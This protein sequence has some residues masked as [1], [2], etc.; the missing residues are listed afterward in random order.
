MADEQRNRGHSLSSTRYAAR[1]SIRTWPESTPLTNFA[2]LS[3][4]L[5]VG[6]AGGEEAQRRKVL[7][8]VEKLPIATHAQSN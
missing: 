7:G 5:I 4:R 8:N 3:L 2:N 1:G 6:A